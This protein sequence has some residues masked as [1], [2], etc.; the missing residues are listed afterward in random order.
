MLKKLVLPLLFAITFAACSRDETPTENVEVT[1]RENVVTV[2]TITLEHQIFTPKITVVGSIQASEEVILS[3]E[4]VAPVKEIYIREG[5]QILRGDL[6]LTLDSEKL[7]LR[8]TRAQQAL[9]QNQSRL[10]ESADNLTRRRELAEQK[11]LSEEILDAARHEWQR[12][13]A[14][15]METQAAMKLAQRDL[16]DSRI[17]SPVNGVIDRLQVE[18]GETVQ[19]GQELML[20]QATDQLEVKTYI[21]ERDIHN[22]QEGNKATIIVANW[23]DKKITATVLT[24][25]IAGDVRTGNFP[26]TLLINPSDD[27]LRPGMTATITITGDVQQ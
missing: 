6:L 9:E 12:A 16:T 10:Q 8:L 23:P 17:L 11:T 21:S 2:T 25:G 19:E 22:I 5:Q 15:V 26:V 20:I 14:S 7:Q 24:V 27:Q 3:A 4:L 13:K 1:T 18:A